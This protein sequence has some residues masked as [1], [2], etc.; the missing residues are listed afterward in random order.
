M[1]KYTK[2]I[3][4]MLMNFLPAMVCKREFYSQAFTRFNERTIEYGFVFKKL[5]EIYPLTVLDIGSG[6]TA[7]PHL[8]RNCGH[9]VTATD[10]IHDYWPYGM[11]NRHYHVINDDITDTR[12]SDK[13]DFITCISVLEH[14]QNPDDAILNMFFLLKPNGHLILTFPYTEKSYV[15]NVYELQGSSYGKDATYITQ[16]Y[17]RNDLER[18]FQDY[19]TILDQEYWQFWE[20]YYWTVGKQIIPPRKVTANEKHQLTC[21]LLSRN[22]TL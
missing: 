2:Q 1:L 6:T 3:I 17:C 18:W 19:G 7:L 13:F 9:L 11:V 21:I 12:L 8:I 20:G 4:K 16:S 14:I 15:R 5:G 10:N 22:N